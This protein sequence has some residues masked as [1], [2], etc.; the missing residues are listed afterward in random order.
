MDYKQTL[1]SLI[2][3]TANEDGTDIHMS[4][5]NKIFVRIKGKMTPQL[6][7]YDE[8]ITPLDTIGIYEY[9][10]TTQSDQS[11]DYVKFSF[12]K[13]GHIGFS[14][15][16]NG[17]RFRINI[18]KNNGGIYI[19]MRIIKATPPLLKDLKFNERTMN[20]LEFVAN[21]TQ[22]MF[23]VVG[24]TGSGKSTTLAAIMRYINEKFEKN[25][26]TLEDPIEYEH[27]SK[28]CHV[29]QKELGRDM[30]SFHHGLVSALREDPDVILIG[31]I[32]DAETLKHA[33][34]A[35]ETGHLVFATLH[36]N[37]AVGTIQRLTSMAENP[38]EARER[39]SSSLLGIIAQNL[40]LD[41]NNKRIPIW[42]ILIKNAAVASQ[43]KEGQD[44]QIKA[45][46]DNIEFSQTYNRTILQYW[47]G[48]RISRETAIK[49]A[50]DSRELDLDSP[51]NM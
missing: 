16:L 2:F 4:P 23:L 18:A 34:E 14:T 20:G 6:K 28:R 17:E 12:E 51:T 43:I 15:T 39:L 24:A 22:G 31:E 37:D 36:T 49:Y 40:T 21:Q 38:I 7:V 50:G 5:N 13:N 10:L 47:K 25:I 33:M 45:L 44:I 3:I 46:M 8:N 42:E 35:A 11:R 48:N 27:L 26:I 1:D 19:V 29:I 30:S 41:K 32:R 9:L